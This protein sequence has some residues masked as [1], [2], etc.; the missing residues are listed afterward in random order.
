VLGI[1][2]GREGMG[3]PF[4]AIEGQFDPGKLSA[5]TESLGKLIGSVKK[6]AIGKVNAFELNFGRGDPA[7]IA[8]LNQNTV[9]LATSKEDIEQAIA[10]ADGKQKTAFKVKEMAKLIEKLDPKNALAAACVAEMPFGG[11]ATT[12]AGGTVTRTTFTLGSEG[13]ESVMASFSVAE[14]I[15]GKVETGLAQATAELAKVAGAMKDFEPVLEAVKGI[16]LSNKEQTITFE[17]KGGAD[18]IEAA[19]K[20]IFF[21]RASNAPIPAG[22]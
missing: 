14:A 18:V 15:T 19:F 7:V 21:A 22:K 11:S 5:A 2:P 4:F 17:G 6:L 13:I 3:A 9:V 20:G 1:V 10:K 8:I 12:N 16:K